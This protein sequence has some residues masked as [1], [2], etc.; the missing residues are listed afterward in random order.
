[1]NN[2]KPVEGGDT[3]MVSAN[4]RGINET[5]NTNQDNGKD[6]RGSDKTDTAQ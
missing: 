2:L 4:L 3:V 5:V 6:Q 1:M